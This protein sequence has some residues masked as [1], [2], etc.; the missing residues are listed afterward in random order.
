[1]K[2]ASPEAND[3]FLQ[4]VGYTRKDLQAGKLDWKSLTPPEFRAADIRAIR[5]LQQTERCA[6]RKECIRKDGRR[7]SS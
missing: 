3:A 2:A 5:E 4:M 7:I 1:L 6:L